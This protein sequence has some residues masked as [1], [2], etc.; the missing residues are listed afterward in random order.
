MELKYRGTV[1]QTA[2]SRQQ[3]KQQAD[4][5]V[6]VYRGVA[7]VTKGAIALTTQ[8]SEELIYRGVRY[9]R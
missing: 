6:G 4:Q 5:P 3:M 2:H 7:Y 1:Y 9:C 8:P